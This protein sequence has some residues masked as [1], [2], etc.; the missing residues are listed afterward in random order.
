MASPRDLSLPTASIG[1]DGHGIVPGSEPFAWGVGTANAQI[2]ADLR[3]H[4]FSNQ[5]EAVDMD[6]WSFQNF[7]KTCQY[8][9]DPRGGPEFARIPSTVSVGAE[10][11]LIRLT[12]PAQ[13]SLNAVG[14][15]TEVNTGLL[16]LTNARSAPLQPPEPTVTKSPTL[17]TEDAVSHMGPRAQSEAKGTVTETPSDPPPL[18]DSTIEVLIKARPPQ[19]APQYPSVPDYPTPSSDDCHIIEEPAKVCGGKKR[20]RKTT[21]SDVEALRDSEDEDDRG[22]A[23]G[24][25]RSKRQCNAAATSYQYSDARRQRLASP[26]VELNHVL[27][28]ATHQGAVERGCSVTSAGVSEPQETPAAR[29][30]ER[31]SSSDSSQLPAPLILWKADGASA[32]SR[33]VS[34]AQ[35][36]ACTN[37]G[38]NRAHLLRLSQSILR[39]ADM[40]NNQSLGASIT[41]GIPLSARKVEA[42][43]LRLALGELRDYVLGALSGDDNEPPAEESRSSWSAQ[44]PRETVHSVS[45]S[46]GKAAQCSSAD[47]TSSVNSDATSDTKDNKQDF[48]KP[49]VKLAR[50]RG[51]RERW[52]EAEEHRLQKCVVEGM[53][54]PQI[55][56]ELNRSESGVQ[57]HCRIMAMRG[58]AWSQLDKRRL[59]AYRTEN[60]EWSEIAKKLKRSEGS[61]VLQW[62]T[63]SQK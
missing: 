26:S 1:V 51:T 48:A 4:T 21:C 43:M 50:P 24:I 28:R 13:K 30:R 29:L 14:G 40:P 3:L 63:M 10:N 19:G 27:T 59:R 33:I 8:L 17:M 58:K 54:W 32:G 25:P 31:A 57:Q 53:D 49:Q 37:C 35:V 34:A 36:Q 6:E 11:R 20:A 9:G 12:T 41:S 47:D 5:P 39:W 2:D 7:Q 16:D 42:I 55:A 46:V 23:G 61:I 22:I 52:S 60:L 62:H 44:A 38:L 45:L 15:I 56:T 18:K